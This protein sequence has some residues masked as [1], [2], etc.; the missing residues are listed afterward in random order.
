ALFIGHLGDR[1]RGAGPI[2]NAWGDVG[3][4]TRSDVR[5]MQERLEKRGVD[6]GTADGLVGFKTRIAIGA[7]EEANGRRATCFPDAGMLRSIR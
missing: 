6:V 4:F 5:A 1:L 2:A 7:W 3:G